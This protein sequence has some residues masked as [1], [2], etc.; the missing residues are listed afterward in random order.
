MS[1]FSSFGAAEHEDDACSY[2]GRRDIHSP[3]CHI[4]KCD[5]NNLFYYKQFLKYNI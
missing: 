1:I 4:C 2:G 3:S 5:T